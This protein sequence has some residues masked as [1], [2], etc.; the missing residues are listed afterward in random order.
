MALELHKHIRVIT[1]SFAI[2][3][4]RCLSTKPA[5]AED[6]RLGVVAVQVEVADP[7]DDDP[8]VTGEVLLL[9]VTVEVGHGP[10]NE[11]GP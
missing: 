4:E 1:R 3:S 11:R 10:V 2:G 9:E 7:P 6:E 8:V 5:P